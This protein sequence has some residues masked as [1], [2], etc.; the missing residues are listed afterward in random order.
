MY[1]M[2]DKRYGKARTDV[3]MKEVLLEGGD[4][5]ARGGGLSRGLYLGLGA[6]AQ[7]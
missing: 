2:L 4:D 6:A 1:K 3:I 5:S 7:A